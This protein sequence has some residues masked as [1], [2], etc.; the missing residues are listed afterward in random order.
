MSPLSRTIHRI[1]VS[2]INLPFNMRVSKVFQLV[3]YVTGKSKND[4]TDY[5]VENVDS[6]G[7]YDTILIRGLRGHIKVSLTHL[8]T[9]VE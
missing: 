2:S 3:K 6:V 8:F 1:E 5:S 4:H 7:G 9:L